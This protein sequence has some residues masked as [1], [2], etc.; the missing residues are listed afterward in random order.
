MRST[1]DDRDKLGNKIDKDDEEKNEKAPKEALEWLDDNQN[2]EKEDFEEKMKEI[3]AVAHPL[4][5]EP[6]QHSADS[7][8]TEEPHDEL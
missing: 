1:I 2:A 4:I 8:G 5:R 3:E 6:C 7:D